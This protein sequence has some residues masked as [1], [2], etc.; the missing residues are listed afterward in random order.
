MP[1]VAR[2]GGKDPVN[3]TSNFFPFVSQ[4]AALNI[5]TERSDNKD[6]VKVISCVSGNILKI[7]KKHR[8]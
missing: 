1:D 7:N 3:A 6:A 5:I 4:S 2:D 8:H